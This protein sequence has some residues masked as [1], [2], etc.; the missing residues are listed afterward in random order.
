MLG[1][2]RFMSIIRFIS[3]LT[4]ASFIVLAGCTQSRPDSAQLGRL[5]D[6]V[7]ELELRVHDLEVSNAVLL[8]QLRVIRPQL[9]AEEVERRREEMQKMIEEAR[10]HSSLQQQNPPPPRSQQPTNQEPHLTPL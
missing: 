9:T 8:V 7:S 5:S 3:W 10:K 4:L 2:I 1:D 6:R